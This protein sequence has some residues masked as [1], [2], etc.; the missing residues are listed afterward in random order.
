MFKIV[1]NVP[2]ETDNTNKENTPNPSQK[3]KSKPTATVSKPLPQEVHNNVLDVEI[4]ENQIQEDFVPNE[5][6]IIV[7]HPESPPPTQIFTLCDPPG[8]PTL[9]VGMH[10]INRN[11][12]KKNIMQQ[13]NVRRASNI[14]AGAVFNNCT[15]NLQMPPS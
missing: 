7:D 14:F 12:Q 9:T 11:V 6:N 10:Q 4:E 5:Q 1:N 8:T 13:S 3:A 2:N 15:I